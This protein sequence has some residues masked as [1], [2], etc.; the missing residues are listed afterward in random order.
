MRDAE[1]WPAVEVALET[2]RGA[3]PGAIDRVD[4][5][6]SRVLVI[7]YKTG[8]WGY[9]GLDADPVLAGHH[10]QLVLTA[11]ARAPT[12][13][14][15]RQRSAP[16]FASSRAREVRAPP[17]R[18]GRS[19]DGAPGGGGAPRGNGIRAAS[20]LP[21]PGDSTAAR[22]RTVGS[23]SSIASVRPHATKRGSARAHASFVLLEALA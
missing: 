17:D 18:R 23:A 1:S 11:R 14:T 21:M 10:L 16:N 5:S 9:D 7:D 20:F 6:P 22:P 19:G 13:P 3:L 2:K 4:V 8:V 12:W 15:R